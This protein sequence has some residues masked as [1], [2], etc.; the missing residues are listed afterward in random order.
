MEIALK[1]ENSGVLFEE[2]KS[3]REERFVADFGAFQKTFT[4]NVAQ[5]KPSCLI[6]NPKTVEPT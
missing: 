4:L 2:E 6:R 5:L 3:R 1:R